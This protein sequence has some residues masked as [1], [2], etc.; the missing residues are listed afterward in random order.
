MYMGCTYTILLGVRVA[1]SL[2]DKME[3][4]RTMSKCAV[5]R[6]SMSQVL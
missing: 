1:T 6:S 4:R 5:M 3:L 2:V